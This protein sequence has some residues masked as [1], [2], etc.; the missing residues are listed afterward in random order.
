MAIAFDAVSVGLK[1]PA[2]G[3]PLTFA[4]TCTGANRK[5]FVGLFKTAGDTVTGVTYGGVSMTLVDK[6]A[7]GTE[8]VYLY[9]LIAPATG[10]NNVVIS[11]TSNAIVR[12]HAIS[13]TGV[14]QTG[15][16]DASAKNSTSGTT[17]T[18][19]LTTIENNCWTV[20]YCRAGGDITAGAGTTLRGTSTTSNPLDSNGPKTPAGSTSL[21]ANSSASDL[22]AT[23]MA[24]FAPATDDYPMVASLG[25]F[26][27]T[28]IASIL[29]FGRKMVAS[30]G[31]YALTSVITILS[32]GRKM[33]A[34]LGTFA[35][36]GIDVIFYYGKM[37]LASVGTLTLTGI[38]ATFGVTLTMI[39]SVGTFVLT[40]FA[41][42]LGK[43]FIILASLG[44]F[45]LTGI[46]ALF[47]MG[48]GVIAS[49]GTFTLTGINALFN[50]GR[51]MIASTGAFKLTGIN[52]LFSIGYAFLASLGTFTLTGVNATLA[53]G[54]VLIASVGAFTL[55]GINVTFGVTLS[56]VASVGSFVVTMQNV[57]FRVTGWRNPFAKNNIS[58]TNTTKNS[59]DW[60]NQDKS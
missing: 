58:A 11:F 14:K 20:E 52:A 26:T 13:Y 21:I 19:T 3:T 29:S 60:I 16:V 25:T 40:G 1:A 37:I 4:H 43:G 53:Y 27:L 2:S 59:E 48:Y 55:T 28:G 12:A 39:A 51:T 34:S 49:V 15:S 56:I 42:A 18:T 32:F 35:L 41:T 10:S 50:F 7:N 31:T 54:R 6:I 44:T 30:L 24:S 45:T 33:V 9:E 23:V 57:I 17:I 46:D 36:T 8:Y 5:L 22:M 47:A 38:N